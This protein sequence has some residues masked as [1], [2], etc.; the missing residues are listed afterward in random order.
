[1]AVARPK[2]I[3]DH[4]NIPLILLPQ[5]YG[6][7]A[8][9]HTKRIARDAVLSAR[10]A[11]ARDH[12]SFRALKQL[13]G[14]KFDPAI[15]R[16]GVDIAFTLPAEDPGPK[17]DAQVRRWI[18]EAQS[19]P[20]FGLN[21][22]GLIALDPQSDRRFGFKANY[23][24]A[25]VLFLRDIMTRNASRFLLIPHVM[26][27]IG[28]PESDA[29]A[30]LGVLNRLPPDLQRRVAVTPTK[31]SE[32]EVKWVISKLEW[33]C[34]TRM[35]STIAALS[36]TVPTAAIAYSDKTLGVFETC[37]LG[38][39][40]I[41]PRKLETAEVVERLTHSFDSR[42]ALREVLKQAIPD[43]RSQAQEQFL[44]ITETLKDWA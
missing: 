4:L 38:D 40:V 31:L 16:E 30:C 1:L 28:I 18:E 33:F 43:V 17:L 20:L 5:T 7:F 25:L 15:H 32:R 10:M 11:W 34:G 39:Q 23:V 9:I 12:R 6:P 21:V 14:D 22:S 2:L 26:T 3:A 29:E 37:G 41:D 13:V 35:H 44:C 42:G 24:D 8:G 19:Q 36:S 27:P